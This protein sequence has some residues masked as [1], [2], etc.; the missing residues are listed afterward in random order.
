MCSKLCLSCVCALVPCGE[1]IMSF[2]E[3]KINYKKKK[4]LLHDISLCGLALLN[5]C[6]ISYDQAMNCLT[7]LCQISHSVF[8]L[9]VMHETEAITSNVLIF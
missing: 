1:F 5:R 8:I 6:S 4:K 7:F 2:T 3:W 9:L